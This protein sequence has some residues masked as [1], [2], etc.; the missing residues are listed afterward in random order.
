VKANHTV[1]RIRVLGL[2]LFGQ[3]EALC[4]FLP[5]HEAAF[6]AL[7]GDRVEANEFSFTSTPSGF[8]RA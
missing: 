5:T 8:Q 3:E 4:C 1:A 6:Q 2:L 7:R